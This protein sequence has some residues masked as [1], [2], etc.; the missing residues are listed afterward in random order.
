MRV[1]GGDSVSYD[2]MSNCRDRVDGVGGD[3]V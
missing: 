2:E 3:C 1:V